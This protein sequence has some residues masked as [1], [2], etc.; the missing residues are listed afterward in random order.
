MARTKQ[1]KPQGYKPQPPAGVRRRTTP[2][3]G[4]LE[5]VRAEVGRWRRRKIHIEKQAKIY[6][7]SVRQYCQ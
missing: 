5:W 2:L 6:K 3:K 1:G 4:T 7:K